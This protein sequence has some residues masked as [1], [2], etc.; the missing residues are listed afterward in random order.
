METKMTVKLILGRIEDQDTDVI[1]N[2]TNEEMAWEETTV[3]GDI[4]NKAGMGYTDNC[5]I[6][7]DKFGK[8]KQN[9]VVFV[10]GYELKAN[11]VLN[12][13]PPFYEIRKTP[14]QNYD[15][16]QPEQD[17]A[18]LERSVGQQNLIRG[19]AVAL[20]VDDIQVT[21][22]SVNHKWYGQ[23][24]QVIIWQIWGRKGVKSVGHH[25]SGRYNGHHLVKEG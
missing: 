10:P 21:K 15:E 23:H 18:D 17:D 7:I 22:N 24:H 3:N 9:D 25:R 1:V 6:L 2:P 16:R 13:F 19:A 11:F 14:V 20:H 8:L 5:K 4:H 12:V